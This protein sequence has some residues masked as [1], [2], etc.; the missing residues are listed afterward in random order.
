MLLEA[1]RSQ[2][3][4]FWQFWLLIEFWEFL[5]FVAVVSSEIRLSV[6]EVLMLVSH[7]VCSMT[8]PAAFYE[9]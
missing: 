2:M 8:Q 7:L 3:V 6:P 4:T 9:L 5:A 1:R